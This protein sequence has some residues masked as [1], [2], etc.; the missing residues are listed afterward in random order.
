[1][2]L[3]AKLHHKAEDDG[4]ARTVYKKMIKEDPD[5]SGAYVGLAGI[6]NSRGEYK[7]EARFLQKAI[8]AGNFKILSPSQ[9]ADVHYSLAFAKYNGVEYSDAAR[10]MGDAIALKGDRADWHILAGWIDLKRNRLETALTSFQK[11]ESLDNRL[12]AA[13][14]GEGDARMALSE[15]ERARRAYQ[16]AMELDPTNTVIVLKLAF[17]AA[18]M[19]DLVEA[20]RLL[21][22]AVRIDKDHLPPD[23]LKKVTDLL[24]E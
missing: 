8:A 16:K 19:N 24:P 10:A 23:L 11:A 14:T 6:E 20:K 18:S 1:M 17:A 5:E 7:E 9:R 2:G 3:L 12:A 4:K 13:Y 22:E 21:D 15:P